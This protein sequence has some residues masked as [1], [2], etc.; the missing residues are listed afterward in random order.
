MLI[1]KRSTKTVHLWR[2]LRL[3]LLPRR[4][5]QPLPTVKKIKSSF[6]RRMT[7]PW[8]WSWKCLCQSRSTPT[9]KNCASAFK[10]QQI[11]YVSPLIHSSWWHQWWL[12][13]ARQASRVRMMLCRSRRRRCLRGPGL[14]ISLWHQHVHKQW[15]NRR[16]LKDPQLSTS[17]KLLL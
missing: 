11:H 15:I 5:K 13:V 2:N 10:W 3:T 14:S 8:F 12:T 4:L 16:H 17:P 6:T 9:S 1:H 7:M